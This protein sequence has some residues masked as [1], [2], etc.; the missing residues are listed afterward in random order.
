MDPKSNGSLREALTFDDVLLR[1]G[2]S[3]LLPS[4]AD[5]RTR[6]TREITLNIP[7]VASAMDTVTEVKMAIAMAQAGGLGVIHR[8]LEPEEQ[9]AQVRQVKKFESGMVVNPVTIAPGA[10]LAD[11]HDL[12]QAHGISGIPV[13]EGGG[14]GRAGK[15]VG[16]LTNRDVRFAT[17]PRQKVAELM[18]KDRLITVSEG[19]GQDE[20]KRLLHQY[21]IEKLLVVDDQY[22]C[23]GLITV[24]DMEK[25]VA[26]PH[27]CKD[28][29]GRLRVAAATTVGDKGFDRTG[30]LIEAGVDL[31]VVD[32][33]HGHSRSVLDAV[34]RI[35]RLSNAVQ[36]V[37]GNVATS[38]GAKALIDAGADAIK[39][40]IG[41]G[42]ICTTRIVAGVGVP[43]LTA[44]MDT[45]EVARKSGTP[46]I[47]DG[48][49]KY[50][51]DLAKA[52]A[53]G[54]D[55]AMVGSLLA[56]TDETPGEVFL[57]QG[58]SYKTYRGMGSVGAMARGSAD[59]Y[60][61][62]DIKDTLKL[63][64]EGVE[65]QVPYKGAAATVLH[66]LAGGLRAAMGYV[67]A[68]TLQELHEKAE[69]VRISGAGMRESHVHD[70][71]ITRESP[72]YPSRV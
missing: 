39:V 20:A 60:F 36:V 56:G 70:V 23:V 7:I 65:G 3:E 38:E 33:A 68:N 5:I 45:V 46:V 2:L 50:S 16:I 30:R 28:E 26:N 44:I 42:S 19:V 48:G 58:R 13:V 54:A 14:N 25:A 59:R 55:C 62:Q 18:T 61:Q 71:T 35:K 57:Y 17:D 29:Q 31:V 37:A 49:I 22:R 32:T 43:Q 52:L 40:G 8:N 21:R 64:P 53:A 15:L 24:K 9:A 67:G 72:N 1:P 6:I 47:A 27:A 51:G 4:D 12:M 66:Q 11:A 69:F 34:T 41:P 63:V 10:T